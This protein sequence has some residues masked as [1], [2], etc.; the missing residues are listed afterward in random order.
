MS[1]SQC[2]TCQHVSFDG[3]ALNPSYYK[4]YTILSQDL[5][6]EATTVVS[7]LVPPC[8]S[9]DQAVEVNCRMSLK[10][11]QC[12]AELALSP[13]QNELLAPLLKIAHTVVDSANLSDDSSDAD[14]SESIEQED[15][16]AIDGDVSPSTDVVDTSEG[17]ALDPEDQ[18]VL[19]LQQ[20]ILHDCEMLKA[21]N[22]QGEADTKPQPEYSSPDQELT[23]LLDDKTAQS[24]LG[25]LAD[26]LMQSE[27]ASLADQSSQNNVKEDSSNEVETEIIATTPDLTDKSA[28]QQPDLATTSRTFDADAE[29]MRQYLS[30]EPLNMNNGHTAKSRHGEKSPGSNVSKDDF[31]QLQPQGEQTPTVANTDTNSG[32]QS[33]QSASNIGRGSGRMRPNAKDLGIFF[34]L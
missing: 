20:E 28:S 11:W 29:S 14:L 27:S 7:D 26:E 10:V 15:L 6:E 3:C 32:P 33:E 1:L 16:L 23:G 24:N 18:E 22:D 13:T 19:R 17:L 4:A 8:Q 9:W 34:T 12:L 25:D 2:H 31:W 30:S 21:E 5:G